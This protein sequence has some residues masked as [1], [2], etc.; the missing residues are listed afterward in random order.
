MIAQA[1]RG[2]RLGAGE[3]Q[4]PIA[5]PRRDD[6]GPRCDGGEGM[7]A[8]GF[9]GQHAQGTVTSHKPAW[10][11]C[12]WVAEIMDV[13]RFGKCGTPRPGWG[14][15]ELDPEVRPL[16]SPPGS[17]SSLLSFACKQKREGR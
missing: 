4:K 1:A 14:W 5:S 17:L 15:F 16:S 2:H 7:D 11:A 13:M 9:G 12:L 8:R 3:E 10:Q 6:K